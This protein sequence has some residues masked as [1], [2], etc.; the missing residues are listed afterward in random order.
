MNAFVYF[1]IG[2]IFFIILAA[3]G[4]SWINSYQKKKEKKKQ[5]QKFNDFI[6]DNHLTIDSKQRFNKNIIGIDRLNYSVVFLNNNTKKITAIRL[7]ELAE[8]RLIKQS[9]KTSGHINRIFLQ[10]IFKR[11][12]REDIILPC[13]NEIYDDVN[14]M[15][16]LSKKATNWAKRI[17]LFREAATLKDLH[18]LSA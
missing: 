11:K 15:M 17:N 7:K 5:L 9:N 3:I 4:I 14:M 10:C 2:F 1:A 13:Y 18:R 16:R 12:E 8:C 6:I